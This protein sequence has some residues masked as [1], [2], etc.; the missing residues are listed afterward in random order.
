ML[1]MGALNSASISDPTYILGYF[2]LIHIFNFLLICL[3]IYLCV[4]V[5]M[6]LCMYACMCVFI[7]IY[8]VPVYLIT[9]LFDHTPDIFIT[10]NLAC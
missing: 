6:F 7:Y 1:L 3:F 2:F 9:I 10:S 8:I 4:C 5:C